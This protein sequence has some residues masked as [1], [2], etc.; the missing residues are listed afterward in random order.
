MINSK[1]LTALW[2]AILLVIWSAW[3]IHQTLEQGVWLL[4]IWRI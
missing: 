4:L 2:I 1:N 3:V